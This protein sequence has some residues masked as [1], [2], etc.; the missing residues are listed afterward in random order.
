MPGKTQ[1][2]YSYEAQRRIAEANNCF[3]Y[4]ILPTITQDEFDILCAKRPHVY[5]KYEGYV[6]NYFSKKR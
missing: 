2:Q 1:K 5:K 6:K 4:E 3:I